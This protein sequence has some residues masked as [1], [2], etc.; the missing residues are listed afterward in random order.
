[1]AHILF[2]GDTHGDH[3]HVLPVVQKEKPDAIIFLGD[4]EPARLF[5][6]ELQDVIELTEVWW[7]HGNHDVD[8]RESFDNLFSSELVDRNLDGR[9]VEI[10][11]IKIAGLGGVFR[12]S[13]WYP[14]FDANVDP[15]YPDYETAINAMMEAERWKEFRRLKATGQELDGLPSPALIGKA[16]LHKS[17]I[18]WDTWMD[19]YS[20]QADIL[21]THDAPSCHSHG[22]VGIDALAQSIGATRV[23]HGHHH[24]HINYSSLEKLGFHGHSVGFRSVVDLNGVQIYPKIKS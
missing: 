10:A 22:F 21:V 19:V 20:Q 24:E 7:I 2:F 8:R 16:L 5:H 12:V 23:F 18:F 13:I 9:V 3:R 11:G 15:V 6:E 14:K 1:M 4:M 17:S